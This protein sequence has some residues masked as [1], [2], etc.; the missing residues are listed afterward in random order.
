MICTATRYEG[1]QKSRRTGWQGHLKET[2]YLDDLGM[3][4]EDNIQMDLVEL[5]GCGLD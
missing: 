5:G 2:D 4:G 1:D 3:E